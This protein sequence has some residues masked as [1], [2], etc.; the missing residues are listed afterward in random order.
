MR[1]F[2]ADAPP[3][4]LGGANSANNLSHRPSQETDNGRQA[5][6]IGSIS[7]YERRVSAFNKKRPW[8]STKGGQSRMS[9]WSDP[10]SAR[11]ALD[12]DTEL[13]M[14]GSSRS[15][16]RSGSRSRPERFSFGGDEAVMLPS[17]AEDGEF[18]KRLARRRVRRRH[19]FH[20]LQSFQHLRVLLP[21]RM[22]I[23]V[24]LCGQ[25]L[26]M[27]RREDHLENVLACLNVGS[28]S[29]HRP[30]ALLM[31]TLDHHLVFSIHQRNPA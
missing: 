8:P 9:S 18:R 20:A 27:Q 14:G 23:D 31:S 28:Y 30:N 21:E 17:V 6:V 11:Y 10:I 25:L 29:V 24:G 12:E 26:T 5:S 15:R 22:K 19:S 13:D 7:D 4:M 16:S 2:L 3:F 1:S